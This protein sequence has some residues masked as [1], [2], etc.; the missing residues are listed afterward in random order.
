MVA[1]LLAHSSVPG[2]LRN[3]LALD[4]QQYLAADDV[5]TTVATQEIFAT[6]DMA[7][8]SAVKPER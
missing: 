4:G 3:L 2:R 8:R 6:D 5:N 1:C 7:G